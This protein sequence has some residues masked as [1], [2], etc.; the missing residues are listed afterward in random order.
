METTQPQPSPQLP[1]SKASPIIQHAIAP[2]L[3]PD[4][5][6]ATQTIFLNHPSAK[7]SSSPASSPRI[8]DPP[9]KR[10]GS[11]HPAM[12]GTMEGGNGLGANFF[13]DESSESE[14]E[15]SDGDVTQ[16]F[17]EAEDLGLK[18]LMQETYGDGHGPRGR[19]RDRGFLTTLPASM[20]LPAHDSGLGTE[21]EQFSSPIENKGTKRAR[22]MS[23]KRLGKDNVR[24]VHTQSNSGTPRGSVGSNTSEMN[25]ALADL[26]K[27]LPNSRRSEACPN[28]PNSNSFKGHHRRNTSESAIADSI[29]D[30]HVRTMRA[31]EALS[32]SAS[33]SQA[34]GRSYPHST[35]TSS[36]PKLSSFTAVRHIKITP[37]STVD[38]ERPAHLPS[39]FIKTPYPFTAKK[40]F[41]KPKSR[42][43]QRGVGGTD[44]KGAG[45]FERLDS[46]YSEQELRKEYDDRKGKHMLGLVCSEGEYD[47][48]SRMER[49]EDAQGVIRSVVGSGRDSKERV[50]W[51]SLQKRAWRKRNGEDARNNLARI[52]VPSDLTTAS[53]IRYGKKTRSMG[54]IDFD[55]MYFAERLR[56]SHHELAGSWITRTFSA[57]KL[58]R[59]Q[60]GQTSTWSGCTSQ[61]PTRGTA[62]LLAR[63]EGIDIFSDSRSPFTEDG[64]MKLYAKPTTGKARYTWVHWARRVAA[65]NDSQRP[66]PLQQYLPTRS[67]RRRARSLDSPPNEDEKLTLCAYLHDESTTTPDTVTT[68]QFVHTL[69]TLRVLFAL[70]LMLALSV[71]AALLWI[72][73]GAA[74]TGWRLDLSRQRSDRVG[75]GIAIGVLALLL[76]GLA[77][78]AWVLLS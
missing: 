21:N 28:L 9:P 68:I 41:P 69:S 50:V 60:L 34:Q 78:V 22:E 17:S 32:P 71:V 5:P 40:E 12:S 72:F 65:S 25:A 11:V 55:D 44:S 66:L 48:R 54:E 47:L 37:L 76:E 1:L 43:R 19:S 26:P 39:H 46:G 73:L 15:D 2:G 63:G 70:M 38:H 53:P 13:D 77:F 14:W 27:P 31:L 62:G 20:Q 24:L 67:S 35:T 10:H 29:I 56:A 33:L 52:D 36:F 8:V 64:L 6:D 61:E 49:N 51:L 18:G 74:G 45:E 42:P 75:S 58:R 30:A 16:T 23:L 7:I 4:S 59:I 57:R 3:P